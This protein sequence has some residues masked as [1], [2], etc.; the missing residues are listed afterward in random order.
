MKNSFFALVIFLL[1]FTTFSQEITSQQLEYLKNNPEILENLSNGDVGNPES[2]IEGNDS[3]LDIENESTEIK[4]IE[5][6]EVFGFDFITKTPKSISST[7]DL[8]VPND[9]MLSLGDEL[10]IIL[11]GGKREVFNLTVG[12]DGTILFPE[13]GS[14]TVFGES[15]S[16]VRIKIENLIDLSYVG[17]EVS[18]SIEKL[19][20]RKIN[21]IGAIENPGTYI[22]NPFST[23]TSSL[24][25]SGGFKD[26]S[27]LRNIKLL[28]EGKEISFD[29]Y[30]LLIF[31]DRGKD[32][33]IQPGD[34]IKVEGSSSFISIE[35]AVIRP[36]VYE[37]SKNDTYEDLISFALGMTIDADKNNIY[38]TE[39][40]NGLKR[41]KKIN[42]S[43][44]VSDSFLEKL[45]V[46][47]NV[48]VSDNNVFVDGYG[49]SKGFINSDISEFEELISKLQF[50][51]EIYPFYA[52]Y[53]FETLKGLSKS[54]VA[55]SIADPETYKDFQLHSNS[56]I[57]FFDRD[58]IIR[59]SEFYL[60]DMNM[61]EIN[62]EEDDNYL[63]NVPITSEFI[64]Y[65]SPSI[66]LSL[67]VKGKITAKTLHEYFG[68]SEK[69]SIENVAVITQI[70]SFSDS[71]T[72]IL[73]SDETVAITLP[74]VQTDLITIS[75][76]GQIL[77]PGVYKLPATTTLDE[78]YILAGGLMENSFENGIFFSRVSVRENQERA[79]VEARTVLVDS[80]LQKSTTSEK[81]IGDI[82]A[83]I[84]LADNLEPTGRITGNFY[85]NTEFSKTFILSDGDTIFIP[86]RTNEVTVE[87][88][89][90]N[91]TSFLYN[92][93]MSLVEYIDAA[94]GYSTYADKSA[95]FIIRANGTALKANKNI[96]SGNNLVIEKG[97]TIVVPRDLDQIEGLPLVQA[98]TEII[99]NIAFSAASLNAITN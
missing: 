84:E 9:Y 67:P 52:V 69:I 79:I 26:Y 27:S 71:Y 17:T 49:V 44:K 56:K 29:L 4:E 72:K 11:T 55:F 78:L 18:V 34:T 1:S 88:E 66:D 74:K 30:D 6:S 95:V 12:L 81:A 16:E 94:G 99:S 25:Y 77:N 90:L 58:F 97:D 65:K 2:K 35:G 22:V 20:A 19:A 39:I 85:P 63:L 31:G 47:S 62:F 48:Y 89:V 37:Y 60:N 64:Q 7:S 23:I 15:I 75:I 53:E 13:L 59:L 21:I 92:V 76:N 86:S 8:P 28:R 42:L 40:S 80:L 45:Y 50:S 51:S 61:E 93:D 46:G 87:G 36:L 73:D 41:T 70:D 43:D 32:I 68:V 5:E 57:Y 33:S 10:K 14:V 3:S 38:V 83:I 54:K 96:F 91:S 82:S 98:A 24:G